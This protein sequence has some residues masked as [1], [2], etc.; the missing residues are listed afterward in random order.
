MAEI[1]CLGGRRGAKGSRKWG[2]PA[3]LSEA[4]A[5]V[6]LRPRPKSGGEAALWRLGGRARRS[7][8][9]EEW[10][11]GR[12]CG[13]AQ[14]APRPTTCR[15]RGLRA[16]ATSPADRTGLWR[17]GGFPA[18][19]GCR[20][21]G[22]RLRPSPTPQP[23]FPLLPCGDEAGGLRE[24]ASRWAR[25]HETPRGAS[26]W[27]TFLTDGGSRSFLRK[28]R[29]PGRWEGG[30]GGVPRRHRAGMA[31]KGGVRKAA[32]GGRV[33]GRGLSAL[34]VAPPPGPGVRGGFRPRTRLPCVAAGGSPESPA[35]APEGPR[36]WGVRGFVLGSSFPP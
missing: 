24:V 18:R 19:P 14:A 5:W 2:Q 4:P 31:S 12:P 33:R 30:G 13:P 23:L 28:W 27:G 29:P 16:L 35:F 7:P 21:Q 6:R 17:T 3:F 10:R 34:G 25:R 15:V 26:F 36:V 11:Q 8:M 9:P 22:P 20:E 32:P 1:R